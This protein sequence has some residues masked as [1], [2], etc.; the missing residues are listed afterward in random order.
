[1]RIFR[2]HDAVPP[3]ARGAVVVVGNFDGVHRG[4]QV[5]IAQGRRIAD[6]LSRPL[7]LVTFEP[8]PRAYF[9]PH[10]P[11][12]RLTPLRIKAHCLE[13]LGVECLFVLHFDAKIASLPPEAFVQEVVA[14]GLG[15]AHVVVGYDFVFG[16]ARAGNAETL[17]ALGKEFGID[18]TVVAPVGEGG[19]I[20]SSTRI[21]EHLAAGRPAEAAALLGR[22]WEIEGRVVHGDKRGR[23]LGVPT[24]NIHFEEFLHPCRGIYAVRAGVDQG[25]ETQWHDAVAS[26]GLRPAIGG[27]EDV[28]EA[29]LFDFAGDLYGKH[30]RVALVDYLR[31]ERN[32]DSLD[33]LAAQMREDCDNARDV[34]GRRRD[35]IRVAERP[36]LEAA[37]IPRSGTHS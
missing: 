14:A 24:A 18:V 20:F 35:Q 34:L 2:H 25:S 23:E 26:F 13:A 29:H 15:A 31:P 36:S 1:M 22:T 9:A 7:A 12:F 3:E 5:V 37:S 28:F 32:F 21:R 10:N 30:L 16:K 19:T 11:P 27:D 17:R 33:D 4:H 6:D 8:H